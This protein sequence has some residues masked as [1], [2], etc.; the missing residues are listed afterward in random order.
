MNTKRLLVRKIVTVIG[1]LL[2]IRLELYVPIPGFDADI[3]F[4]NSNIIPPNLQP[5]LTPDSFLS[6]SSLGIVPYL[7]SSI[8]IQ[9]LT[10]QL[11]SLKQ[12]QKEGG[13]FGKQALNQYTRALT[14]VWSLIL[15]SILTFSGIKPL[16]FDW[17]LSL[18]FR[19]ILALTTGSMLQAWISELITKENL[20]NGPSLIISMNIIGSFANTINLS[21]E[22]GLSLKSTSKVSYSVVYLLSYLLITILTVFVQGS[23]KKIHI[24][25]AKQLSSS[26][27]EL[28]SQPNAL[29][30]NYIPLKY[31]PGG[32][33]PLIF[34][35]NIATLLVSFLKLGLKVFNSNLTIPFFVFFIL[36]L[37]L[38][39]ILLI[40]F[41]IVYSCIVINPLEL[42]ETLTK[43]ATIIPGFKQGEE[44]AQYL[45]TVIR[46]YAFLGGLLLSS[47]FLVSFIGNTVLRNVT[48]LLILLGTYTDVSSQV[49]GYLVS[50]KYKGFKEEE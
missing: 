10:A 45:T 37:G 43:N 17:N 34:S 5:G 7:N 9:F 42:S 25:S 22:L 40:C 26:Y 31:N 18:A 24:I 28:R 41:N 27:D 48:S 21:D 39:L 4:A 38:N 11:P 20:G 8:L 46:R 47:I 12:L 29:T 35:T 33:A 19:A 32:I 15:S 49:R 30:N 14:L 3:Y 2:V 50:T 16:V 6:I 1:L 44:T 23:Y 13:E 36:D